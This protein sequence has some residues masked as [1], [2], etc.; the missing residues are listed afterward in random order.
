ML[1]FIFF[2]LPINAV[3]EGEVPDDAKSKA[4]EFLDRLVEKELVSKRFI[5]TMAVLMLWA[6]GVPVPSDLVALVIGYYFG[7]HAVQ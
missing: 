2:L 1:G 5:V 3:G 4:I 6:H 7:S